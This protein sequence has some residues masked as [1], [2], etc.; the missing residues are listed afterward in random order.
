[1]AK[2]IAARERGGRAVGDP[3]GA[4]PHRQQPRRLGLAFPIDTAAL[5]IAALG[6]GAVCRAFAPADSAVCLF[7]TAAKAEHSLGPPFSQPATSLTVFGA[8]KGSAS[9][10][11]GGGTASKATP[12][13]PASRV[14][15]QSAIFGALR[16]VTGRARG[17]A[18]RLRLAPAARPASASRTEAPS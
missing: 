7:G 16:R 12:F 17:E 15:P 2:Q 6:G 9:P 5:S 13:A 1:M 11:A 8:A 10:Q 14:T 18:R 3:R 4:G